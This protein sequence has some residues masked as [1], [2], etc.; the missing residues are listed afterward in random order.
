MVDRRQVHTDVVFTRCSRSS[1]SWHPVARACFL[2]QTPKPF[3]QSSADDGSRVPADNLSP[4]D[5]D[6]V[7]QS[8]PRR[9][10]QDER[11]AGIFGEF[12]LNP[13]VESVQMDADHPRRPEAISRG[14]RSLIEGG[15]PAVRHGHLVVQSR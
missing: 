3:A 13:R 15:E 12:K 1:R 10:M 2:G 11:A 6:R 14:E 9:Q 4:N 7:M 5:A 8:C